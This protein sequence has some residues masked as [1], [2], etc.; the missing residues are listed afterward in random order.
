LQ[1]GRAS[2]IIALRRTPRIPLSYPMFSLQPVTLLLILANVGVFF[3]Q[4]DMPEPMVMTY[5]LWPVGSG[6]V[7]PWQVV[8]YS[9]L[10]ASAAHLGFNMLA[11]FMFGA[12]V[13][14]ELGWPKYLLYYFVCVLVAALVQLAVTIMHVS[15]AGYTVGASGG[16]F[17]LLLAFGMLFPKRK[18]VPL[19]L[20]IPMPAWLFVTLYGVIEL[21]LGVTQ[22][23][24]GV[25]HFAHLGGMLGGW[26][27][28]QYWLPRR[29]ATGQH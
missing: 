5:A 24:E 12:E 26:L 27:L 3:L 10:H 21:W 20:P 4:Q 1:A 13:E 17:G 25:A 18:L 23:L 6:L 22:T 15:L 14:R 9:F 2:R 7:K 11:L 8:S 19:I 28:L 16:V 29:R